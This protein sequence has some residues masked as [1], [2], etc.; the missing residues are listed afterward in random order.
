M[1]AIQL[2]G[3]RGR[4]SAGMT[5]SFSR[6]DRRKLSRWDS[7]FVTSTRGPRF[8]KFFVYSYK[9]RKLA[10]EIGSHMKIAGSFG[11]M[12]SLA[13]EPFQTLKLTADDQIT[14]D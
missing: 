4:Y 5:G 9:Y 2:R 10:A 14:P 12:A 1:H 11:L 13:R 8:S 7:N 6:P 3:G